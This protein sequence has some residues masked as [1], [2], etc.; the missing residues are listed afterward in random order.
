M[1]YHL[2]LGDFM[3][4]FQ[5]LGGIRKKMSSGIKKISCHIYESVLKSIQLAKD[6]FFFFL[7]KRKK[8]KQTNFV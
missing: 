1:P 3:R 6:V 8:R 4:Y 2:F 5:D 7:K